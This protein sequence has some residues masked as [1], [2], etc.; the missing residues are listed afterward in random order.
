M[1]YP[2]NSVVPGTATLVQRATMPK[3]IRNKIVTMK[4]ADTTPLAK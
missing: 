3:T 1:A 4:K 2:A